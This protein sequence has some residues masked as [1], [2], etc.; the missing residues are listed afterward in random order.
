MFRYRGQMPWLLTFSA[1]IFVLLVSA[2]DVA[3]KAKTFDA[4]SEA[5]A[6]Q[7]LTESPWA[8]SSTGV[9]SGLKNEDQ[10]REGGNMGQNHGVGYD[11]LEDGRSWLDRFDDYI[12][13]IP[14]PRRQPHPLQ[15][16]VVWQSARPIGAAEVK[17]GAVEPFKLDGDGYRIAVY[18]IPGGPYK[19]DPARLGNPLK[20][21]AVLKRTGKKD[22]KAVSAA[23]F[24]GEH[25]VVIVYLFP[26]TAEI[27]K[28]D[29]FVAFSAQIGRIV[30]FQLFTIAEMEFRGNL[31]L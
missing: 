30:V 22:V 26:P 6:R 11:G 7:V 5:D 27:S 24:Q 10:R 29:G 19:K 2:A 3:W 25:G 13:G 20:R 16:K 4:W 15:L 9:V 1:V 17:V 12:R 18:G 23:V 31:E 14:D 28:R 8:K 21:N